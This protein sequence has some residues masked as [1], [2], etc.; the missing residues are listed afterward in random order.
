VFRGHVMGITADYND[1]SFA[2]RCNF[3]SPNWVPDEPLSM[4]PIPKDR[5]ATQE[6]VGEQVTNKIG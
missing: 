1:T 6:C 4:L 2:I 3:R 5:V